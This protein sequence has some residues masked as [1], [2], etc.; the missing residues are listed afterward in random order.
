MGDDSILM[1]AAGALAGGLEAY[2]QQL[3]TDILMDAE[4]VR[5]KNLNRLGRENK[6]LSSGSGMVDVNGRE[7]SVEEAAKSKEGLQ[8]LH[9]YAATKMEEGTRAGEKL[10]R[11]LYTGSPE[12]AAAQQKVQFDIFKYASGIVKDMPGETKKERRDKNKAYQNAYRMAEVALGIREAPSKKIQKEAE[13]AVE[14]SEVL[15]SLLG[16]IRKGTGRPTI[17]PELAVPIAEEGFDTGATLP[18]GSTISALTG[19]PI[20]K[21]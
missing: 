13:S 9:D 11:E 19:K 15:Q 18:T 7:A 6:R 1:G 10:R 21:K 4:K 5:T 20:S 14:G 17:T 12:E 16:T 3:D 8:P 2:K